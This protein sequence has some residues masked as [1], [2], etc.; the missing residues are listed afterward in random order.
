LPDKQ[1]TSFSVS[2]PAGHGFYNNVWRIDQGFRFGA[3][4]RVLVGGLGFRCLLVTRE[5]LRGARRKRVMARLRSQDLR[6][7]FVDGDPE[8]PGH[9]R[10][11]DGGRD[12]DKPGVELVFATSAKLEVRLTRTRNWRNSTRSALKSRVKNFEAVRGWTWVGA[13]TPLRG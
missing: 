10:R 5:S 4:Q 3:L 11:E 13:P 8:D 6:D 12:G 7:L 2:D 1:I 9:P